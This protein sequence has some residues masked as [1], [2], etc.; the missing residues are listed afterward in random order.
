MRI[1][2]LQ[3]IG[4]HMIR[5]GEVIPTSRV[6]ATSAQLLYSIHRL[7]EDQQ[8]VEDWRARRMVGNRMGLVLM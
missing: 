5:P 1:V 2:I 4:K 8:N 3:G 6:N 7:W